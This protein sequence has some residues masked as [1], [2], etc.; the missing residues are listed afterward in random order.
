M[1]NFKMEKAVYMTVFTK[2]TQ[3]DIAS[4]LDIDESTIS[5][6]KKTEKFKSMQTKVEHEFLGS[7]VPEA[8]RALKGLLEAE[9]ES[10]R[11]NAAA[12]VLDRCG[13]KPTNKM[14]ISG[15][16]AEQSKLDSL[17]EQLGDDS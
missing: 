8:L 12:D 1:A 16:E 9:S 6:W 11:L 4:E 2:L 14:E 5:R 10:V 3:R 13:F 17:L 7:M 15:L